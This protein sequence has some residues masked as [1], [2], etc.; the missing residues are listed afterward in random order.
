MAARAARLLAC[1]TIMYEHEW[2]TG[3]YTKTLDAPTVAKFC[4]QMK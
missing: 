2:H 1:L 4:G 3:F